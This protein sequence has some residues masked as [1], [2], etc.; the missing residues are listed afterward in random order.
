M[1]VFEYQ[2][3]KICINDWILTQPSNGHGQLRKISQH[4]NVNSVVMSQI[5]RGERD[6]NLEQALEVCQFVGFTDLERD[7]FLLL[8]QKARAGT[9]KLKKVLEQQIKTLA[10]SA[11]SL[12]NR[13][14]H[15][16][17]TEENKAVFYSHWYYSAIRL[18]ASIPKLGSVSALANYL[19]L[20]RALVSRIID[21]LLKNKLIV[22]HKNGFDMGPSVTHTGHDSP[23]VNRHHVNWRLQALKSMESTNDNNLFYTGPMVLSDS[24]AKEIRKTLID[25]IDKTTKKVGP[26][27]SESL[28]CLNIDW[29]SVGN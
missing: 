20:D 18:G 26:S 19:D 21:F 27:A 11:Q 13:I 14:K 28:K 25:L 1:N 23:Y 16:K 10:E 6:L 3:Y 29:F 5:F 4:L 8:V 17:F 15:Q 22:T 24:L 7:Y 9:E 12:K 2:S